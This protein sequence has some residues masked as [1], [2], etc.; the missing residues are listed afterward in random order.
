MILAGGKGSRMDVLCQGRPKPV[1]PFAGTFKVI[2]FSLSNCVHS[3]LGNVAV[4]VDYQRYYISEYLGRWCRVN[5]S[6]NHNFRILEPKVDYYKGTA[7]AVLQNLDYLQKHCADTVLVLAGDH[8]YRMD[9]RKMLAFH[10][11]TEADATVGVVS[12]PV[13]QACRFGIVTTGAKSR[14]IDFA[15]KPE[16]PRNNLASMGI[17]IFKTESLIKLLVEDSMQVNSPHDF[18]YA[19]LPN[20]V[21]RNR[22]FAYKFGGYWQD[23]GTVAAYYETNMELTREVP[24]LCLNGK[25]PI[26]TGDKSSLAPKLSYQGNVKH[27][28]V[29]PDCIIRGE[30]DNSVLSPGVRVEE[31]AV[32]RNSIIM[33]NTVIGRHTIVENCILDEAVNVGRFCYIGFGANRISE[34]RDITV[35]GR[36]V[37]VPPHTAIGRNCKVLS[38]V[39]E[40]DFATKA[41]PPGTVISPR[42]LQ[43]ATAGTE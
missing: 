5:A 32:V 8:V 9:Y 7:D 27:S 11:Q 17:Y 33:A 36:G 37:T 43:L 26:L 15:E 12:V 22:V 19:L 16:K 6:S 10:E 2:D 23:I 34:K 21:T 35:L 3:G 24:S 41:V 4:L 39:G 29:S 13:E 28:L 38:A 42:Q 20:M 30:V 40:A 1:L 25:W 31:Q 18:G 14:V